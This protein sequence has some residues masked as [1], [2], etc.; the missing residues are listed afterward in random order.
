MT[1]CSECCC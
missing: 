1:Y